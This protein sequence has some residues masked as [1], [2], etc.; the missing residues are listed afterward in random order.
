MTET[1]NNLQVGTNQSTVP[2]TPAFHEDPDIDYTNAV[3]HESSFDNTHDTFQAETLKFNNKFAA[4]S[5]V[6]RMLW[7]HKENASLNVRV[8]EDGFLDLNNDVR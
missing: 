5:L 3:T 2:A 1:K 6:A 7:G 4:N 8:S